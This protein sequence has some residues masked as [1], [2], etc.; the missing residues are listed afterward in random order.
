MKV[1]KKKLATKK[2]N[3]WRMCGEEEEKKKT[4]VFSKERKDAARKG[5]ER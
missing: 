1:E 5:R 2:Q 3:E 4:E